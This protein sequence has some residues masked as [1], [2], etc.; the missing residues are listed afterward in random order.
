MSSREQVLKAF[1]KKLVVVVPELI[2]VY[3]FQ[4]EITKF[5]KILQGRKGL[6]LII[7]EEDYSLEN[8]LL[9]DL[10][11]DK[12]QDEYGWEEGVRLAN[13]F[14]RSYIRT[15]SNLW[16]INIK[17]NHCLLP[18]DQINLKNSRNLV[19][20]EDVLPTI[21]FLH[22]EVEILQINIGFTRRDAMEV[23]NKFPKYA[24]LINPDCCW[25]RFDFT[26]EHSLLQI[27]TPYLEDF[28]QG[29]PPDN[30]VHIY[31]RM[32]GS[33]K[34]QISYSLMKKCKELSLPFIYRSEFWKGEN[35][36]YL[37]V[38]FNPDNS[39]EEVAK[40]IVDKSTSKQCVIFLDEV[41][42]NLEIIKK[43]MK[44]KYDKEDVTIFVVSL[45]KDIPPYAKNFEIYDISKE[46]T[47][48]ETQYK[49]LI[50]KLLETSNLPEEMFS[51]GIIDSIVAKTRLWNLSSVRTT[52]TSIIL[53]CSIALAETLKKSSDKN[54]LIVIDKE[55]VEKWAFL[56][57]S[58]WYQKYNEVHDVHAEF[59]VF[60]GEKY[61]DVDEH[62]LHPLP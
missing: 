6:V 58:P 40:W 44:N 46:Y 9:I 33:G 19:Y 56:G 32:G 18:E 25:M 5:D 34:T 38:E 39:A 2:A 37:E 41:D 45:G 50:S 31:G 30:H 62:Y 24:P 51:K 15:K 47:Y 48:S 55:T 36:K 23:F 43:N 28:K 42:V 26:I 20:G 12:I 11:Y 29:R 27:L 14:S 53:T 59:L 54:G 13:S 61:V 4:K 16:H 52:P 10:I 60:D 17:N 49:A 57:T 8:L 22:N 3:E 21:P 7:P 1:V 35:G